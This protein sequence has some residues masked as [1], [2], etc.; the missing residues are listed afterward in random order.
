[1]MKVLEDPDSLT[2]D[3]INSSIRKGVCETNYFLFYVVQLFKNKGV[4]PLL[5]NIVSWMPS[6]LDR[7]TIKG[8]DSEGGK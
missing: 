6:P 8:F 7:G 1:M 4:Q 3:E 2:A 5:D